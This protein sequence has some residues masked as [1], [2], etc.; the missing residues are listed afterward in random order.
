MIEQ[1]ERH[2]GF[3]LDEAVK[4]PELFF[5]PAEL[6]ELR[7]IAKGADVTLAAVVAHNLRLFY[8][9]DAGGVHFALSAGANPET[10]LL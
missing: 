10:G 3:D 4:Q 6:D 1:R 9:A 7:G 8:D 5:G 2:L